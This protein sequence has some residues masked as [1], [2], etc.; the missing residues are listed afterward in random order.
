MPFAILAD[1]Y[2]VGLEHTVIPFS[3]VP[4]YGKCPGDCGK[5]K[6]PLLCALNRGRFKA[7]HM[8][9]QIVIF[10]VERWIEQ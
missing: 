6:G 3:G 9:I 5:S 1:K 8:I 7:A 10:L 2:V 4:V